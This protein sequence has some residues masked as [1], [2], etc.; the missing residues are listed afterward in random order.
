M[1][2]K[3]IKVEEKLIKINQALATQTRMVKAYSLR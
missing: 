2:K 3:Q 1:D